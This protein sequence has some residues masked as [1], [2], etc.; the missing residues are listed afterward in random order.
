MSAYFSKKPSLF[1]WTPWYGG[2]GFGIGWSW[3]QN[4]PTSHSLAVWAWANLCFTICQIRRVEPCRVTR[5]IKQYTKRTKWYLS[6]EVPS[7][8]HQPLHCYTHRACA[9]H[10][11]LTVNH[12]LLKCFSACTFAERSTILKLVCV[13][14][15]YETSIVD[16]WTTQI[17]HV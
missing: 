13:C 9:W 1:A 2:M 4:Q 12:N 5:R 17:W 3:A 6:V 7:P 10:K 16:P 14:G 15:I 8:C 11:T